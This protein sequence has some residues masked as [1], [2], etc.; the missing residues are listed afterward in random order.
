MH[1]ALMPLG[2][3]QFLVEF[4]TDP[5]KEHL[6]VDPFGGWNRTGLAAELAGRPWITTELFSQYA[7]TGALE[8]LNRPGF[9]SNFELSR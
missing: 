9:K 8:F 7:V 1:G 3:A 6:V 5:D 2:L 4:L